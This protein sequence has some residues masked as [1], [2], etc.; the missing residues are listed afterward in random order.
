MKTIIMLGVLLGL[1]L[2]AVFGLRSFIQRKIIKKSKKLIKSG[3]ISQV[4]K[5]YIGGIRQYILIEGKS[6]DLPICLFLHGGPGAPF[7]FGVSS[8]SLFPEI[9]EH[10]LAVYYDQRGAGKSYSKAIDPKSMN[11]EQIMNDI[12]ELVD[13]LREKFHQD[14]VMLVGMSWGTVLGTELIKRYPEKFYTYVGISQVVNDAESQKLA[15]SWL[16]EKAKRTGD[17]RALH[18]LNELGEPPYVGKKD[19]QLD[20]LISKYK[21]DLYEDRSTK[22]PN[23]FLLVRGAFISPDYTLLDLWKALITGAKFSLLESKDLQMEIAKTNYLETVPTVNI[24]VYFIQGKHD[25]TTNYELAKQFFNCI[26]APKGK[27]FITLEQSAHY[28]NEADFNVILHKLVELAISKD[29]THFST[30]QS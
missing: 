16:A 11:I 10:Y 15:K 13:Y 17:Q 23:L 29:K 26:A 2:V 21:G 19:E 3:G 7:P 30:E 4:E 18:V 8:R 24:P 9:T 14:Q 22:K 20:K 6:K 1:L 12:H 27:E 25:K 5:L 28:P